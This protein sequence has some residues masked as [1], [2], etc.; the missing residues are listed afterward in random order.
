MDEIQCTF[1]TG[2]VST[3]VVSITISKE[4]SMS[5]YK[6]RKREDAQVRPRVEINLQASSSTTDIFASQVVAL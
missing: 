4:Y 6:K 2:N 3:H 5:V 1:P